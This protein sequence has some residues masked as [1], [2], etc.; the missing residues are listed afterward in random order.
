M[1]IQAMDVLLLTILNTLVCCATCTLCLFALGF[2]SFD[3]QLRKI[4]KSEYTTWWPNKFDV[5]RYINRT[6][7]S[8]LKLVRKLKKK[9][10]T[11]AT[12]NR[13]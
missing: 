1:K 4:L 5:G 10:R 11:E 6:K 2:M 8:K 9:N 3:P 12:P 7:T 13:M